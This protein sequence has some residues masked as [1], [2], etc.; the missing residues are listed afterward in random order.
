[1]FAQSSTPPSLTPAS[2]G[3]TTPESLLIFPDELER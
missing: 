1:M 3:V 2:P